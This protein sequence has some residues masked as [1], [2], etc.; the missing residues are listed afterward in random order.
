MSLTALS[1]V[2]LR[3]RIGTKAISPVEL[4]EACIARIEALNP[5]VNA[6]AGRA[7]GRARAEAKAAEAAVLAGETLGRL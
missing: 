3:R 1:A 2:E 4:L 7:F 5:A 6:I